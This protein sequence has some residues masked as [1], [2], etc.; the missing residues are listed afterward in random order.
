MQLVKS[1]KINIETVLQLIILIGFACF[2][3]YIILTG[4][5]LLYVTPRIVPYIK[6]GIVAMFLLS[7]FIVRDIFKPKRKVNVTPYLFFIVPLFMAFILPA[8]SLDS[9][10]MSFGDIKSTQKVVST[11]NSNGSNNNI[12]DQSKTTGNNTTT[13]ANTASNPNKEDFGLVLQGD[14]VVINSDN[15]V[16]WLQEICN[17]MGNY[18]GKKIQLTG[19]VFKDKT[20]KKNE[21][22]PARLMMSCC[23][24]DLQ[25]VGILC[26]YD[27]AAGLKQDTW[28]TLTGKIEIVDYNGEKTPIIIAENIQKTEK[29][30]KDY[31]YPY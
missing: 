9:T 18:E 7:L 31:V 23:S 12:A 21:F 28:I 13:T 2:F 22:V 15:F 8:K 4:K 3:Y 16:K 19:F 25:P 10:S 5:V 17:N 29:P 14:T 27:K 1:R 6:F 30:E 20:F 26:R 24:A 11:T